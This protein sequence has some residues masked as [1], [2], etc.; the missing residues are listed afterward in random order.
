MSD[1]TPDEPGQ[2][3]AELAEPASAT[4]AQPAPSSPGV[5]ADPLI[6]AGFDGGSVTEIRHA[7]VRSAATAG[8][9][10]QRL[11]DFVLAVNE[12]TTNAVRHAG[13]H[14]EI[15]L[16]QAGEA[17]LCEVADDGA[18]IPRGLADGADR[19]GPSATGGWGLWL[20]RRLCDDVAIETGPTG[21]TVRITMRVAP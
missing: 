10:G 21:T 11:D 19:P 14:G 5:V 6:Q 17:V 13:G 9:S 16:W 3:T 20:T 7:V 15:R 2:A 12:L 4:L 1:T 18:G 8:L